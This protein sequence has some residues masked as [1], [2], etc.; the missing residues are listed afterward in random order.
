M[1]VVGRMREEAHRQARHVITRQ[2]TDLQG[3][4]QLLLDRVRVCETG[5]GV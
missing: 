5:V 1:Q 3:K 2:A 4:A